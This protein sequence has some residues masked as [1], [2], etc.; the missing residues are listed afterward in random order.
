MKSE[1]LR[2]QPLVLGGGFQDRTLL[3]GEFDEFFLRPIIDDDDRLAAATELLDS[4]E[5][6]HVDQLASIHAR[7]DVPVQLVWGEGDPFFPVDWARD[8]VHTFA[9]AQLAVIEGARLFAH[10]RSGSICAPWRAMAVPVMA[11][12]QRDCGLVKVSRVVLCWSAC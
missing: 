3:N 10:L 2:R 8:M 9:D 11:R 12:P 1:R 7:I 5:N 6:R 4:F